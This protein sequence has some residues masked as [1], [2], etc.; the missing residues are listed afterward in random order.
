MGLLRT[1]P[2][3]DD[4]SQHAYTF[5]HFVLFFRPHVC[6]FTQ[7]YQVPVPC[8]QAVSVPM[9]FLLRYFQKNCKFLL[10]VNIK[11][12]EVA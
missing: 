10:F 8:P 7:F 4:I 12:D 11:C 1:Q 2:K 9:R 3:K 5:I 6:E